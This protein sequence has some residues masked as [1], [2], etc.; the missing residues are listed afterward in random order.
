MFGKPP[1]RDSTTFTPM[2]VVMHPR[3]LA[4]FLFFY[5]F[6]ILFRVCLISMIRINRVTLHDSGFDY[7]AMELLFY[8]GGLLDIRRLR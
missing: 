4:V 5:V 6:L 3:V 2:Q 1:E 7:W 8:T